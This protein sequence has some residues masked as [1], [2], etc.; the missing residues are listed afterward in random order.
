[1]VYSSRLSLASLLR[2]ISL[3]DIQFIQKVIIL[4]MAY[5][6]MLTFYVVEVLHSKIIMLHSSTASVFRISF[7]YC[8]SITSSVSGHFRWNWKHYYDC[9]PYSRSTQWTSDLNQLRFIG[10]VRITM[11]HLTQ[12]V[13]LL[14]VQLCQPDSLELLPDELRNSDSFGSFKWFMKTL[15]F[16]CY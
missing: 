5:K 15:L 8:F 2:S 9:V 4:N 12:H 13:W 11:P 7:I 3:E 16:R 10:V 6:E 14:G 1:V